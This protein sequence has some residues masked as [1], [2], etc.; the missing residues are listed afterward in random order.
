MACHASYDNLRRAERSGVT[1]TT[2]HDD[3]AHH[4]EQHGPRTGQADDLRRQ[5]SSYSRAKPVTMNDDVQ[6]QR[7][8]QREADPAVPGGQGVHPDPAVQERQP[9]DQDQL[10]DHDQGDVQAEEP[11]DGD[12]GVLLRHVGGE[13]QHLDEEQVEQDRGPQDR[14]RHHR[15]GYHWSGRGLTRGRHGRLLSKGVVIVYSVRRGRFSS[16]GT[17]PI[18]KVA[19]LTLRGEPVT[20]AERMM[21]GFGVPPIFLL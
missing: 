13:E 3:K 21:P 6:Q 15:G 11:A 12:Q 20:S 2:T 18:Q 4:A 1:A 10:E 8:E 14:A 7:P 19:N 5:E 16:P 9:G 17:A